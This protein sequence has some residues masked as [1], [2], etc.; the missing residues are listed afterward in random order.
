MGVLGSGSDAIKLIVNKDSAAGIV[1]L[2]DARSGKCAGFY[3]PPGKPMKWPFDRKGRLR[4]I[5]VLD[6]ALFSDTSTITNWYLP[7]GQA[8][9]VRL[10]EFRISDDYWMPVYVSD[11]PDTLVGVHGTCW[12]WK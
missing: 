3:R 2:C 5:S 4:A 11:E 8:R 6:S 12:T 10:A 7:E 1:S 9:W